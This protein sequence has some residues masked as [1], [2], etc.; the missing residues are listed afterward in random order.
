MAAKCKNDIN[1]DKKQQIK[2]KKL[3]GYCDIS[4]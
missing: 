2:E 3:V 1:I 4:V